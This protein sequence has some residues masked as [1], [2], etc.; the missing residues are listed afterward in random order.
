MFINPIKFINL[1]LER[2]N[3]IPLKKICTTKYTKSN[4]RNM[5]KYLQKRKHRKTKEKYP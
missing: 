1:N 4:D 3:I 5:L 2:K